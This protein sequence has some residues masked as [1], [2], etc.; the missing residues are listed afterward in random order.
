VQIKANHDLRM[1]PSRH[2]D[3]TGNQDNISIK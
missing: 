1:Q 3:F 2:K